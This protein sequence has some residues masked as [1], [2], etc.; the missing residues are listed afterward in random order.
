MI[1]YLL[2]IGI[3]A[4]I[5]TFVSELAKRNTLWAAILASLPLTSLLAFIW[6]YLET[7]NTEKIAQLSQEIVWLVLPSLAIFI[8]LPVFL[9][10]GWNFW[11]SLGLGCGLSA[12]AYLGITRLLV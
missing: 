5:I 8:T 10:M 12:I 6:L 3:T 11:L 4:L 2:K 9:R 1:A 7:G